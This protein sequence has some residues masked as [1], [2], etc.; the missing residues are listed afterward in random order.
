[1]ER[2]IALFNDK[3][4]TIYY[5]I[6]YDVNSFYLFIFIHIIILLFLMFCIWT[7]YFVIYYDVKFIIII[8]HFNII[9]FDI[10]AKQTYIYYLKI[11]IYYDVIKSQT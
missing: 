6:Y 2:D 11:V 5:V 4:L 1:M 10:G 9:R 3:Y 7:I 8:I